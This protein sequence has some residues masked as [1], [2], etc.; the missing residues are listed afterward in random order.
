MV[1]AICLGVDPRSSS[2]G[3][4]VCDL[5]LSDLCSVVEVMQ[6][7]QN[8]IHCAAVGYICREAMMKSLAIDWFEHRDFRFATYDRHAAFGFVCYSLG[9]QP[10]RTYLVDLYLDL[11]DLVC[12][13]TDVV[14]ICAFVGTSTMIDHFDDAD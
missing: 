13:G 8:Q 11:L 10:W 9:M 2:L 12:E 7:L 6:A 3:K 4:M 14:S 5:D 1:V